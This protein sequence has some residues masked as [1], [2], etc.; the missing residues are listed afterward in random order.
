[1][2]EAREWL[3]CPFHD[4]IG[5]KG[6]GVDCLHLLYEVYLSVGLIEVFE[7]PPY[8][9]QWFQ[10]RDR[11]LFLEGVTKRARQIEWKDARPGDFALFNMGRHAA[12]GGILT[13]PPRSMVHAFGLARAVVEEDPRRM[14][15]RLHSCWSLF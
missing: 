6:R 15:K 5:I 12:H 1:M 8:K 10:H 3:G 2:R 14:L 7:I 4:C 9:P 11:P 13:I